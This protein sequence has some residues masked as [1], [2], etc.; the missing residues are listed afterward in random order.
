MNKKVKIFKKNSALVSPPNNHSNFLVFQSCALIF[1][2]VA[3]LILK[4]TNLRSIVLILYPRGTSSHRQML[5]MFV[6]SQTKKLL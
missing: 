6:Q 1:S 2:D 5:K 3:A 4:R